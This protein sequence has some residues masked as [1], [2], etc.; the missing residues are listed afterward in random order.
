MKKLRV[1][2]IITRPDQDDSSEN[3]ESGLFLAG[4]ES[5][6]SFLICGQC[7][8]GNAGGQEFARVRTLPQLAPGTRPLQDIKTFFRLIALYKGLRPDIIHTHAPKAGILG[9]WAGW[10][11][12]RRCGHDVKLIHTPHGHR[13]YGYSGGFET[14]LRLTAERLTALI[15]DSFIALTRGEALESSRAGIGH[16]SQWTWIHAGVDTSRAL[17]YLDI[18]SRAEARTI[19][20]RRCGFERD[21]FVVGFCGRLTAVK[22]VPVLLEAFR[23]LY[24]RRGNCRL[25]VI[26]AGEEEAALKKLA[27][28][29]KIDDA[30][31]FAGRQADPWRWLSACDVLAHPSLN[32]D[33]GRALIM[34]QALGVPPVSSSL[35]GIPDVVLDEM[36]GLLV[37][38]KDADALYKAL[39]R[40]ENN[41]ALVSRLGAAGTGWVMSPDDTRH[42]KFSVASMLEQHI[43]H[44]RKVW[45]A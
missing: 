43:N 35:G 3:T 29:L 16:P 41:P 6:E 32:E 2:H 10:F 21:A 20:R 25:A 15:T 19:I 18:V 37:P 24:M 14:A 45:R 9:R 12:K 22:G 23:R 39:L 33:S 8:Q 44:Y 38:P 7:A 27:E 5:L 30:V 42:P 17:R 31:F 11:Y 28:Q 1:V 34:A 13:L 36:T 4:T 26:G 40:L